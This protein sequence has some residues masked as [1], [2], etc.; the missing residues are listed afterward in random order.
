ME[1]R[2]DAM[3]MTCP[4]P[5]ILAKKEMDKSQAGDV[6]FVQV[7]NEVATENLR[8]LANSQEADYEMTKLGD[9]HYEVKITVKK[10]ELPR[11]RKSRSI[12]PVYLRD[13]RIQ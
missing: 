6:V 13:K 11:K 12:F 2:V 9:K 5:V 8:K 1:K 7:D 4:K 10:G 3:G